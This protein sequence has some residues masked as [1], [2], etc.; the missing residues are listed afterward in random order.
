M[1]VLG[2][3]VM[4]EEERRTEEKK[5]HFAFLFSILSKKTLQRSP[6]WTTTSTHIPGDNALISCEMVRAKVS[7]WAKR[8]FE[9]LL[10]LCPP[11]TT[12]C[13]VQ[14]SSATLLPGMIRLALLARGQ[15]LVQEHR[16]LVLT[17]SSASTSIPVPPFSLIST[18]YTSI[19]MIL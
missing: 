13:P 4:M 3:F 18:R 9:R 8:K 6:P 14:S 10:P 11:V 2:V 1:S 15:H 7:L 5:N 16:C 12:F 17:T 19:A